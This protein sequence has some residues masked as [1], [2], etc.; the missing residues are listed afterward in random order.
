MEEEDGLKGAGEKFF[1]ADSEA[2]EF[3]GLRSLSLGGKEVHPGQ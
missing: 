1:G 2:R 3:E